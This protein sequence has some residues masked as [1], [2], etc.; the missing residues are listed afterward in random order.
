MTR[1]FLDLLIGQLGLGQ[2]F[3]GLLTGCGV[4]VEIFEEDLGATGGRSTALGVVLGLDVD[5]RGHRSDRVVEGRSLAVGAGDTVALGV[6]CLNDEL[7][8]GHIAGDAGQGEGHC[9]CRPGDSCL[10]WGLN[11]G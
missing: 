5:G 3:S 8:V 6:G 11:A 7:Q 1:Q 4:H 9:G 2:H 10:C